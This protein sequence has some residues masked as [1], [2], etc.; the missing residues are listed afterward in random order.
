MNRNTMS[1]KVKQFLMFAGPAAVLFCAVVIVPFVY[2]IYLTF[3][4]WDGVA[5]TKPFVGAANYAAMWITGMRL[6]APRSTHCLQLYSLISL[7]SHWLIL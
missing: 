7:H 5:K 2:G 3:T 6:D 1:Y 4:S